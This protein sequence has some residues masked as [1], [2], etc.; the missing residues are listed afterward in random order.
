[1]Q[2][3]TK[4]DNRVAASDNLNP[5]AFGVLLLQLSQNGASFSYHSASNGSILDSGFIPCTHAT[6]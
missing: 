3:F 6:P 1:L 4:T 2:N 5:T